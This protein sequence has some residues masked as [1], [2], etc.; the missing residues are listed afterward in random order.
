MIESSQFKEFK[1][2]KLEKTIYV[3]ILLAISMF[4]S[5]FIL[6]ILLELKYLN[7]LLVIRIGM[8]CFGILCIIVTIT[9]KK[10]NSILR[11]IPFIMIF[12][13]TIYSAL[14]T[15]FSGGFNSSYW[16]GFAFFLVAWS[17]I[18]PQ[19]YKTTIATNISFIIS[20]NVIL[21]SLNGFS[22]LTSIVKIIEYNVFLFGFAA[23]G[24]VVSYVVY[25]NKIQVYNSN[26]EIDIQKQKS[27]NLL[28]NILPPQIADRLKEGETTISDYFD[29]VAILFA[30]IVGFTSYCTDKKPKEIVD[31]LNYIFYAFDKKTEEL[32]LEKIK[33]IG[34]GYMVLAGGLKDSNSDLLKTIDLGDY[35]IQ[36]IE[37]FSKE[38][39]TQLAI[40]VGI[41]IGSVTAGVIGKTKFAFDIWGDSVN[42]ASRMESTGV[43]MEIQVTQ[44]VVNYIS[45]KNRCVYR[46]E[47]DV[48]GKG[49]MKTYII[50]RYKRDQIHT[51]TASI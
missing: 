18:F 21:Y 51:T 12:A 32:G 27:E 8:S 49:K 22:I 48:K 16:A 41:H 47:I 5:F 11:I 9:N 4:L 44:E 10:N 43:P 37:N 31:L 3:S 19:S 7:E 20:Y 40:R 42:I 1:E 50:Q 13:G 23:V 39:N 6:D 26:C 33:T 17:G 15:H 14:L 29:R 46:G 35:M 38:K 24:S 34:D 28:L 25:Q 36:F 45:D 2:N 30:D